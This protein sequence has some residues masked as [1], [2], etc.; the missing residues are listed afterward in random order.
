MMKHEILAVF[1][2][3]VEKMRK[4]GKTCEEATRFFPASRARNSCPLKRPR[5]LAA[6]INEVEEHRTAK[7]TGARGL[8]E[9]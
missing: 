5:S 9:E 8:N 7:D 2:Q 6:I 1:L 3:I 4:R